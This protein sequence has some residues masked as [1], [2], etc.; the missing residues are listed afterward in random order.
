MAPNSTQTIELG[1]EAKL[2]P[3]KELEPGQEFTNSASISAPYFGVS[4]TERGEALKNYAGEAIGYREYAGPTAAVK[5]KVALPTITVEKTTGASGFPASANAEV[6]QSFGWRVIVKNTSTVPAKNVTVTD[7]L[8]P[9]WEYVGG[10]SFAPGGAFAPSE[11]GTLEAGRELTW[12]TS[13]ELAAG[14]ST[15]L[16]YQA[17]PTV[18][19]ES[20]PGTGAEDPGINSASATVLDAAGN[21]EDAKGKFAAGPAQAHGV[22]IVPV[23][24]VTKT[25]AKASVLA[26][27]GDSFD[28]RVHNSGSGAAREVLLADTLPKGMSYT[29]KA[30]TASPSSGFSETSASAGAV[31]WSIA[32]IAAGATVEVTVP[33]GTEAGLVNGAEL[34]NSVAVSSVE[35]TTPVSASGTVGITTGADVSAE[36]TLLTKGNAAPGEDVTFEVSA[37]DHGPSTAREVKLID[38]L[39]SGLSYVS[40]T[41][42][43]AHSAAEVTCSAGDLAPNQTAS[44]QIVTSL[45]SSL[46]KAFNNTVL[47]ESPTPD[48]ELSNNEASVE[49]T[50][51]PLADLSLAKVALTPEVHDGADAVFDLTATNHGPSDATEA[52]II[53]TLPAGLSYVSASG[54]SCSATG[55]EVSCPLGTL[56][57]G[58]SRTIELTSEVEASLGEQQLTN[59][60]QIAGAE[61]DPN[62]ANNSSSA[63]IQTGPAPVVAIAKTGPVETAPALS[64]SPAPVI[65][66]LDPSTAGSVDADKAAASRTQVRLRKLVNRAVVRAGGRLIYRLIVS[67]L[68]G[69][70]ARSL[71]LCDVIPSQATVIS[72]GGGHLSAGR[73]CFRLATLEHGHT[74]AF[75]IVLRADSTASGA[76]VNRAL[77]SGANFA[78]VYAHARTRVRS[79]ALAHRESGVTG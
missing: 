47:A 32:S 69:E 8:P 31:S 43:C 34:K 76:I 41:P 23:L 63:V 60:A 56:A 45:A 61:F 6:N 14:A 16:T 5:A 70:P 10:A 79:A 25:P 73:I 38:K 17:R 35:E 50:P 51:H 19:A 39:P 77:L 21:S 62:L 15:T 9:N 28:I 33:V 74:R 44:F 75:R 37:T 72:R 49:V 12:S 3:V 55:Q 26:G 18:K 54:A 27:E 2:A 64:P 30:A 46:S 40:S 7:T 68:G 59:T 48:P 11:S 52:K 24:E 53:D 66:A 57:A 42:A 36:K 78:T 13:I 22:L 4:E 67:D 58:A 20:N 71:E 65:A 1:Y 29:A